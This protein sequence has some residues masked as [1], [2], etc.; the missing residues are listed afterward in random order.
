MFRNSDERGRAKEVS[1]GTGDKHGLFRRRQTGVAAVL[2][3][4]LALSAFALPRDGAGYDEDRRKAAQLLQ[5]GAIQPLDGFLDQ[6]RALRGGRV[7]EVE[8]ES[9]GGRYFYEVEVLDDDGHLWE[10]KFDASSGELVEEE[11]EH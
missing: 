3:I 1:I 10:M 5:E 4:A 9:E 8:L 6:A 11:R 7:I 2:I